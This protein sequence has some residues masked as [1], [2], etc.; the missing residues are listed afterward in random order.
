[1]LVIL[2]IAGIF[3]AIVFGKGGVGLMKGCVTLIFGVM[4][5]LVGSAIV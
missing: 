2:L 4:L 5:L 3:I 1:M